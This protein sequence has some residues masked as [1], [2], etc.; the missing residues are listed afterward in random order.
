MEIEKLKGI[1]SR[2]RRRV[3]L[4]DA[5]DG[6]E[7]TYGDIERLSLKMAAFLAG[8]G[9]EKGSKIAMV[10]PNCIESIVI[11]FGC[12][13]NGSV[14]IP[15]N[16]LLHPEEIR[17]IL[18]SSG[19]DALFISETGIEKTDST[20]NDGLKQFVLNINTEKRAGI[21]LLEELKKAETASG[22][23][24]RI[25]DDDLLAIVYTSGTTSA[26]KGVM[27]SYKKIIKNG[28]AFA[29][30]LGMTADLRFYNMLPMAYL[31]GLYNL[32]LI[33]LFAEGSVVLDEAFG[34]KLAL[35]F[36][37]RAE[38]FKV[39]ALWLVPSILSIILSL[40]RTEGGARYCKKNVKLALV[41]TAPLHESVK[42][43][44]EERYGIE[45][46][47][48]YG[49]SE[50]FF[51]STNS[52]G[53]KDNKGVGKIMPGC[54]VQI[55]DE[56]GKVLRTDETGE[57]IVKTDYLMEG[58]YGEPA[59]TAEAAGGR[60]FRTG[61]IGHIDKDG[62]L[63]V[64]DRKKDIIKRGGINISPKEIEEV[65]NGNML[66]NE[67]SVVGIENE[68][69]GEEIIAVV[70]AKAALTGD[71]IIALCKKHL[72]SFKIPKRIIFTDKFPRSVTGKIQK[73]RL[74]EMIAAGEVK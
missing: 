52:P 70:N 21:N 12:M 71:E 57:I 42:K 2:N 49:L 68:L 22:T 7:F 13:Q 46:Y 28:T 43:K 30:A 74:R 15:V 45:L 58:Y 60:G 25:T 50:T 44:F 63:F 10:L 18:A 37:K 3:F 4:V 51:I 66:V 39:N 38:A 34:P 36:W 61:D 41:G 73:N 59:E 17:H 53:L 8:N 55:I 14:L 72:A 29:N 20:C 24:Q 40:D 11:Y 26:P 33:P 1:F 56:S 48:N 35:D 69:S 65:I 27:I 23:F 47:E 62:Y 64:T 54:T 32:T 31:G 5:K 16:P 6:Q 19:A 9:L 67:V